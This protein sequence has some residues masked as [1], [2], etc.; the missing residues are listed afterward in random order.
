M[1]MFILFVVFKTRFSTFF[2]IIHCCYITNYYD[3]HTYSNVL[4][5]KLNI[6]TQYTRTHTHTPCLQLKL[7]RLSVHDNNSL[8]T[9]KG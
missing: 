5:N 6:H 1:F 2:V 9:N 4:N 8:L 7:I 3:T